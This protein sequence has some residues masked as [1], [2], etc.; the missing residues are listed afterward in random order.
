MPVLQDIPIQ[1]KKQ[2]VLRRQGFGGTGKARPE[3]ESLTGELLKSLET[4]HLLEPRATYD[5]Y[6]IVEITSSLVRLEGGGQINGSLIPTSFPEAIELVTMVCTIGPRLEKRVTDYTQG[7]ETL[8]GILLDGIGSA[9]VDI[10][11]REVY[12]SI[13][14]EVANRDFQ[15]G[16]PVNPGMPGLPITEQANLLALAHAGE[17]GVS[18]TQSGIM[19]PRKS[20]SIITAIGGKMQTWSQADICRRCKLSADCPYTVLKR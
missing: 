10:L 19:V 3:I 14:Q 18:L 12:H 4:H 17:I 20:T 15:A 6:P 5:I 16:S 8:K 13:S 9:A 2:E 1:L 7:H 11:A